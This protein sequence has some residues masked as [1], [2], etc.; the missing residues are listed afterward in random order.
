M[1]SKED[2]ASPHVSDREITYTNVAL[3]VRDFLERRIEF[4]LSE[5]IEASNIIVDPGMGRFIANDPEISWTLLRN[6]E[7]IVELGFPV[8]LGTSRKGFLGGKVDER[9]LSS[10]LTS[11]F[12]AL[13]GT[14]IIRTHNPKMMRVSL[15]TWQ[16]LNLS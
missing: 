4:A 6:L 11:L 13:N 7:P 14:Q 10:A 12:G 3:E 9:E 2:G 8:M 1:Y 15:L 16:K 5:G